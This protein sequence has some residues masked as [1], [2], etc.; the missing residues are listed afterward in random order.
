MALRDD[1][2]HKKKQ[3]FKKLEIPEWDSGAAFSVRGLS[4]KEQLYL[5]S[6]ADVAEPEDEAMLVRQRLNIL[7]STFAHC[8]GDERGERVYA[9]CEEATLQEIEAAIP[10]RVIQIIN[11]E[12]AEFTSE[13][14]KKN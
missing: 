3:C 10:L 8:F 6:L 5:R 7:Y 1:L 12:S 11:R 9:D 14:T 4:I 2:K 13:A